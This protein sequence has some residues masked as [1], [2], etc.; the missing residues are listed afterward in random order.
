[1]S[2]SGKPLQRYFPE[3]AALLGGLSHPR[4]V[5]DGELVIAAGGGFSFEALQA[6]LHPA[7]SRILRLSQETPASFIL[8]DR[9]SDD[10]GRSPGRG[11]IA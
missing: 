6:R 5:L 1:M 8:F 9:L 4:F 11:A 10:D 2:K 7:Q 3:V